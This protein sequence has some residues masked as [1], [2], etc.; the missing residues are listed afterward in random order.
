MRC[1]PRRWCRRQAAPARLLWRDDGQGGRPGSFWQVPVMEL[2]VAA[3]GAEPPEEA[4]A[5]WALDESKMSAENAGWL[6]SQ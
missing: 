4:S 6:L 1:V 5:S 2:V 3:Q